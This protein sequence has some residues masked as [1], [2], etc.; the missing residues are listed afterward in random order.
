M[1]LGDETKS[2]LTS[3]PEQSIPING[4]KGFH[5][6]QFTAKNDCS[7]FSHPDTLKTYDINV[8]SPEVTSS[9]DGR[10]LHIPILT[11]DG[12]L[13]QY[14]TVDKITGIP[15]SQMTT[16]DTDEQISQ[17]YEGIDYCNNKPSH[18]RRKQIRST[19]NYPLFGYTKSQPKMKRLKTTISKKANASGSMP[20]DKKT[21]LKKKPTST[22]IPNM[23]PYEAEGYVDQNITEESNFEVD[24][25]DQ[26]IVMQI[27]I[28]KGKDQE[29]N[30]KNQTVSK[31]NI[32]KIRI[33]SEDAPA[34]WI[35]ANAEPKRLD[36]I[37]GEDKELKTT[38]RFSGTQ[39]NNTT[40]RPYVKQSTISDDDDNTT[41]NEYITKNEFAQTDV[42][43]TQHS[44]EDV[45]WVAIKVENQASNS[46]DKQ[47]AGNVK[48]E[49]ATKKQR[50]EGK[51]PKFRHQSVQTIPLLIKRVKRKYH[52]KT[53]VT[54]AK[55]KLNLPSSDEDDE[56]SQDECDNKPKRSDSKVPN[57]SKKYLSLKWEENT[58]D[59]QD[60]IDPSYKP[61]SKTVIQ[62]RRTYNTR[63]Q[64]QKKSIDRFGCQLP[65]HLAI[66]DDTILGTIE[67]QIDEQRRIQN[68]KAEREER[69]N[70]KQTAEQLVRSMHKE[71]ST[72]TEQLHLTKTVATNTEN[73]DPNDP[74]SNPATRK[75]N[76]MAPPDN[77]RKR[78]EVKSEEPPEHQGQPY[79]R[80]KSS[81]EQGILT[82][83]E[84]NDNSDTQNYWNSADEIQEVIS[85]LYCIFS[86]LDRI[87]TNI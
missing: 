68:E 45:E 74:Q 78:Y 67:E 32:S 40:D 43:L 42:S 75:A 3:T 69:L 26:E 79:S 1:V 23:K 7:V 24:P 85:F 82:A 18:L 65:S 57:N 34:Q 16:P 61:S 25:D 9:N 4:D 2:S 31:H 44:G 6:Q 87:S 36:E 38:P 37:Y 63:G 20:K 49:N 84:S 52:T 30:L 13:Y 48:E 51:E 10:L 8:K 5:A 71:V 70:R 60:F 29:E 56:E 14:L 58:D 47:S 81:N 19:S 12:K 73:V 35:S 53:Q 50:K 72:Q 83:N 21:R 54:D 39:T 76:E 41:R 64:G 77:K 11:K 22:F 46:L 86:T 62:P 15:D 55:K 27:W 33:K 80:K 17:K 59:E 28:N 66:S